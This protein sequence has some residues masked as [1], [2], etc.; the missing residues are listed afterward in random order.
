[1]TSFITVRLRLA[2]GATSIVASVLML[3]V[4]IGLVPDSKQS[5]AAGRAQLCESLAIYNSVF[6]AKRDWR[7]LTAAIDIFAKHNPQ[8][9]SIGIRQNHGKLLYATEK[10]DEYWQQDNETSST[11][12]Q[13]RVPLM[14]NNQAWGTVE[15][16]FA[17][18]GPSGWLGL[19]E[20]P[21]V[22]LPM[23][24]GSACCVLL[25]LYL[26]RTLK[27]L[28]P[29]SAVPGR[30]R[31][32]LDGLAESLVVVDHKGVIRFANRVFADL[33]GQTREKIVGRSI[34]KL[35]WLNPD[36]HQP[37]PVG[38]ESGLPW[39]RS[40]SQGQACVGEMLEFR[41]G[42]RSLRTLNISCSPILG[43]GGQSRGVMI[44]GDDVTHLE[45]IKRQLRIAKDKADAASAAKSAFVANM[46]HE[47]RTPLNAV[48]GFADVLRRGMAANREEEREYL[49]LIHRSG[50]HL[51]ELINNILDLAKIESGHV[52]VET[53][54]FSPHQIVH[55][56]VSVLGERARERGLK[57]ADSIVTSLPQT[58]DSD[59]TKFRQIVTN[60]IGNA[61]K[62]TE[63]GSVTVV[64][65]A[66]QARKSV[67]RV[68]VRD[69]GIG[70]TPEQAAKVFVAFEQADQSTTRRFGGTGLGLSISKQ[71]AEALGGSLTVRS[72]LGVGSTFTL[73]LPIAD[74]KQIP[75]IAP[76]Q[77][78]GEL[79]VPAA[80]ASKEPP[81]CLIGR[82]I[83]VADDAEANRRLIGLI[84]T[85]AG[86]AVTTVS[87]GLEALDQIRQRSFDLAV[88]D[89]QMPE[90]DGYAATLRLREEGFELP[91]IALTG[92]A[93]KGDRQRCLDVG[94]HDFLTKPVNVDLLVQTV[95]QWT[96]AAANESDTTPQPLPSEWKL[97]QSV[98]QLAA[99]CQSSFTS[100]HSSL[101]MDDDEIRE[102]VADYIPRM[103]E[104]I[105]TLKQTIER[106]DW[107]EAIQH[108]HWL[109]GSAGTT[110]FLPIS[111]LANSLQE[112][113]KVNQHDSC[114]R[115]IG[116][117]VKL[118]DRVALEVE[119]PLMRSP[120]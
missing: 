7:S 43:P 18:L 19:I 70:M 48:L 55:D 60:L 113:L 105:Q 51:L 12:D 97:L 104:R 53:L 14:A 10:H 106:E 67:L 63:E 34:T 73:E 21:W 3:A 22:R 91:I 88:I 83:L 64:V 109:K 30:V 99:E 47:I 82:Q 59:P 112:A 8:I 44:C 110:G 17:P 52:Q 42:D 35:P 81:K 62:F 56:V 102:I 80:E 79:R 9:R 76:A 50:K 100:L 5:I 15:V 77:A 87:N 101:P 119:Q 90:L 66:V 58:I 86:A 2:I 23:C 37:F 49:D 13:I 28:D 32:A 26:G 36:D 103:K 74:A 29:S 107:D 33:A 40:Q 57:L 75:W 20:Q 6:I 69:T 38:T 85:R 61:I 54:A 45:D 68:E 117:L 114:E 89:M 118:A 120:W 46:S 84:L 65:S 96:N 16:A 115:L 4:L 111:E 25:W 27:M 78:I 24:V 98:E 94:C 92:N 108:A 39:A 116:E 93:M 1:M 72:E 31:E 41:S 11:I 71:F 95:A